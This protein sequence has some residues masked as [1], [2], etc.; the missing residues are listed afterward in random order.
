MPSPTPA[1]RQGTYQLPPGK[2]QPVPGNTPEDVGNARV[3]SPTPAPASSNG[4]ERPGNRQQGAGNAPED[5]GNVPS[6]ISH[7]SGGQEQHHGSHFSGVL[8]ALAFKLSPRTR[9]LPRGRTR[10][11]GDGLNARALRPP[12]S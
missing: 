3:P 2:G 9:P 6:A 11:R 4:A 8:R 5:V 10:G 7:S 1:P 12:S